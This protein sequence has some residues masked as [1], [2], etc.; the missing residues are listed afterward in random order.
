MLNELNTAVMHWQILLNKETT[1]N[2]EPLTNIYK[3]LENT[4]ANYGKVKKIKGN[5]ITLKIEIEKPLHKMS[6]LM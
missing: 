6:N 2:S 5:L 3:Q 4:T 1:D